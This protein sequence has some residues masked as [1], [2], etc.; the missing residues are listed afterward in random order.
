VEPAMTHG[1]LLFTIGILLVAGLRTVQPCMAESVAPTTQVTAPGASGHATLTPE[2]PAASFPVAESARPGANEILQ[3]RVEDIR[4][5]A[6]A[7]FAILVSV[8]LATKPDEAQDELVGVG[9]FSPYPPD[10]PGAYLLNASA[11]LGK[12]S[13]V[14]SPFGRSMVRLLLELKPIGQALPP[15]LEVTVAPPVWL[16][17]LSLKK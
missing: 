15:T 14:R 6:E 13:A 12:F 1:S 5:P 4:N 3:V 17:D 8:Y 11:A 9:N 16:S 2:H 10:R 7:P